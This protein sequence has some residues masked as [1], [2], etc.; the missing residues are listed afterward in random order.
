MMYSLIKGNKVVTG[1]DLKKIGKYIQTKRKELGLTQAELAER[2]G[3]SNKS[4]S[5]WERGVCLPDVSIYMELCEILGVSLNEFIAGEDLSEDR[6]I[7]KSEENIVEIT[8]NELIKRKKL[9]QFI[10]G[11]LILSSILVGIIGISIF[12]I[13]F[14][15]TNYL[16][17]MP[18]NS[19]EVMLAKTLYVTSH[20]CMYNYVVDDS[21]SKIECELITYNKGKLERQIV[22]DG[23]S[24]EGVTDGFIAVIH[25]YLDDEI[26]IIVNNEGTITA[27]EIDIPQKIAELGTSTISREETVKIEKNKAFGLACIAYNDGLLHA[28]PVEELEK[29]V[30]YNDN[31]YTYLLTVTFS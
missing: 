13:L 4:V 8:K 27:T 25:D 3:M 10:V 20:V 26:K 30:E 23:T 22:M 9:K 21:F 17:P 29:G 5:K 7:E 2:L 12:R 18:N 16:E 1:M 24:L 11:L 19:E 6:I 15:E 28:I 14:P 31:D